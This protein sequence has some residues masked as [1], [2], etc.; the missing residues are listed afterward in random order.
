MGHIHCNIIYVSGIAVPNDLRIED[1]GTR[2]RQRNYTFLTPYFQ[3]MIAN[4]F[5]QSSLVKLYC[6][7]VQ[8]LTKA[9]NHNRPLIGGNKQRIW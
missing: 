5:S 4:P 8:S 6:R 3:V 7:M 9:R 2:C 1:Q